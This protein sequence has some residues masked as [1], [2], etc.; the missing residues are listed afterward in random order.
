[1]KSKKWMALCLTGM[2]AFSAAACGIAGTEVKAAEAAEET[3][4]TGIADTLERIDMTKWLYNEEDDVYYQ[5][6]ISYCTD[7]ADAS[8]ETLAVFV[9]GAYMH[10]MDNGDGTYSC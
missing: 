3:E 4:E 2:I 5:T 9:P 1:M 8:C 7:P 6:G 10:A